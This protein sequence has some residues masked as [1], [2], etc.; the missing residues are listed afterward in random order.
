MTHAFSVASEP[1]PEL[2]R[3]PKSLARHVY[4]FVGAPVRMA[5]LP[6]E[7]SERIGLTSL[8]AER[9]AAVLPE[10]KGRVLDVGAGDNLLIRLYRQYGQYGHARGG[11]A[12]DA[13]LS[14]GVDTHDWGGGC[15]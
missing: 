15:T 4:D 14:V 2:L 5:I 10:L 11:A 1:S 12:P 9:M 7:L 13:E 3:R 6:D 8:R